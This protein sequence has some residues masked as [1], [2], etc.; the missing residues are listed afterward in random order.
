MRFL[1]LFVLVFYLFDESHASS[2]GFSAEE[3]E[4]Y[5]A[6]NDFHKIPK[7][8]ENFKD[9]YEFL[10]LTHDCKTSEIRRH[11]RK[12]SLVY[13]PDKSDSENAEEEFRLLTAATEIL[14][15]KEQRELYDNVLADGLPRAYLYVPTKL[16]KVSLLEASLII[17]LAV[18][19]IHYIGI[20]AGSWSKRTFTYDE[21]WEGRIRKSLMK[22]KMTEEECDE[23]IQKLRDGI[24]PKPTYMDLLPIAIPLCIFSAC[25]AIPLLIKEI[26][27][28]NEEIRMQQEEKSRMEKEFEEEI[29]KQKE[30]REKQ[31]K[32]R[33][34]MNKK[35]YEEKQQ[36]EQNSAASP[37]KPPVEYASRPS[38]N[39][40][41]ELS[42]EEIEA[43]YDSNSSN[44]DE[45]YNSRR[46]GGKKK[47]TP[48]PWTDDD[49]TQLV[50]LMA[51]YPGGTLDRWA[52]I[53]KVM[54][55]PVAIITTK[56]KLAKQVIGK[57]PNSNGSQDSSVRQR[58]KQVSNFIEEVADNTKASSEDWSQKQQKIFEQALVSYPKSE[59]DRWV[60]IAECVPDKSTEECINR[61][62]FLSQQVLQK[63]R[64]ANKTK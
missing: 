34:E 43:M 46:R 60:K 57:Q 32:R 40:Q 36:L 38:E 29:R 62:K 15:N 28:K 51:K 17:T 47:N 3:L 27:M 16:R 23:Q 35:K 14:K 6:V 11:F 25:R 1:L 33:K 41:S 54:D 58:K 7:F 19:I 53:S 13:H 49:Q 61:Y 42:I 8:K 20:W 18:T 10:E 22:R 52:V 56:A 2:W 48:K 5:D 45:Y 4:V 50:K 21:H 44:D 37:P 30:K 24:A 12:L 26:K 63:R 39:G 64:T 55:Q 9:F 59:V 31:K